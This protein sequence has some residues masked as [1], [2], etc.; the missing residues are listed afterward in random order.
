MKKLDSQKNKK[1]ILIVD[2]HPVLRLGLT[3]FTK[4]L[5]VSY[6]KSLTIRN[7]GN[8]DR[9]LVINRLKSGWGMNEQDIFAVGSEGVLKYELRGEISPQK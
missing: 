6:Y 9:D 2:A 5:P 4:V 7:L 8:L 3:G 1:R